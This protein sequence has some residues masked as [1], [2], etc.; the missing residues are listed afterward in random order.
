VTLRRPDEQPDRAESVS[1][2]N[3]PRR[4]MVYVCPVCERIFKQAHDQPE[5]SGL[6]YHRGEPVQPEAVEVVEVEGLIRSALAE[7]RERAGH[8]YA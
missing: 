2:A 5:A 8:R 4:W 3:D 6:C 7:A 1:E